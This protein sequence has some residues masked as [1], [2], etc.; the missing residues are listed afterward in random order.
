M[1]RK[2]FDF[3]VQIIQ[4]LY[5]QFSYYCS[6]TFVL[7]LLCF[8]YDIQFSINLIFNSFMCL[9]SKIGKICCLS[10]ILSGFGL[11]FSYVFVNEHA[12]KS[13][14][15]ITTTY[16]LH[17]IITLFW[18][19]FNCKFLWWVSLFLSS[20]LSTGLALKLTH[21][22]DRNQDTSILLKS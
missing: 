14:D 15:F 1:K 9:E 6:L 17:I 18:N 20:F 16:I 5:F 2:G 11:G 12:R 21:V 3:K 22:V 13:I 4:I 7:T 19:S 10:N 8:I